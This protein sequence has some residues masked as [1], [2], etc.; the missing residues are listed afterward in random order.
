[1]KYKY[2]SYGYISK[3]DLQSALNNLN[4]DYGV[5]A[6]YSQQSVEK[7]CKEMILRLNIKEGTRERD[8]ALHS[9]K[10]TLILKFI[11]NS[12]LNQFLKE[13]KDFNDVYFNTRYP[14]EEFYEVDYLEAKELFELSSRFI[15]VVEM[16]I[17]LYESS[18]ARPSSDSIAE[19]SNEFGKNN[20]IN[21][22]FQESENKGD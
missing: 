5:S 6:L 3:K 13:I 14:G 1:M 18:I 15:K 10:I 12:K 19:I 20:P 2:G 16:E 4:T 22:L 8:D 7:I 17:E 11:N 9:H 21:R